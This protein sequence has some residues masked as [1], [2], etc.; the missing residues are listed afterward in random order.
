MKC[1]H[2]ANKQF[3]FGTDPSRNCWEPSVQSFGLNSGP[4]CSLYILNA[5][6]KL[7]RFSTDR[8]NHESFPSAK[9][10]R[11]TVPC[12]LGL[13]NDARQIQIW[14]LL[15][16]TTLDIFQFC[17]VNGITLFWIELNWINWW[18]YSLAL[19]QGKG[20]KGSQSAK[21][22]AITIRVELL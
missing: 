5:R 2:I 21:C 16:Y 4:P 8:E 7:S 11:L 13:I 3:K 6:E 15:G 18:I 10:S 17:M 1:E 19:C 12:R 22:E 9:I 20:R 14:Y